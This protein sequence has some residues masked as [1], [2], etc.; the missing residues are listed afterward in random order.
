ML[1]CPD[2]YGKNMLLIT[3]WE[4]LNFIRRDTDRDLPWNI[5]Q[6]TRETAISV[7]DVSRTEISDLTGI[8]IITNLHV[9]W[10]LTI[11]WIVPFIVGGISFDVSNRW[12]VSASHWETRSNESVPSFDVIVYRSL[13]NE[14]YSHLASWRRF[15]ETVF[16]ARVPLTFL[17]GIEISLISRRNWFVIE[18][19]IW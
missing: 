19:R 8:E 6:L 11:G 15:V 5:V 16:R 2:S 7:S 13:T 14:L 1:P 18:V 3:W 17:D 9:C 12:N 10:E 4:R